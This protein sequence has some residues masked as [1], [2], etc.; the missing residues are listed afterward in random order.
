[1]VAGNWKMNTT[2]S[3]GVELAR[4]VVER[5][6]ARAGV[7][8]AVLPS[9]V[10]LWPV[11][12]VLAASSVLLGAQDLFWED[13]G[14]FTGEV[15]PLML[16]GWCD[17][18]LVGH[19][20]RR[21]LLGE[22]DADTARKVAAA[23][24]HGLG[25]ILAVGET[26]AERDAGQTFAVIDRQLDA[27]LAGAGEPPRPTEW[28]VAYEPVWAIGTGRTATPEQADEVCTH[29]HELLTARTGGSPRVLYGG[30]VSPAN[31][32]DLFGRPG[33][34]GGLI[35]GASLDPGAFAAIVAAAAG[36]G[37]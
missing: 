13:A 25:V 16:A 7:E 4:A 3:A 32:A 18:V 24:R 10:H 37:G 28:V 21:H 2:V 35:G 15:S 11:R 6:G 26:D 23:R 8:V 19:S 9:F 20:E 17:L 33:I 1:M 30:S 14:A 36:S 29:I 34:D 22:T 27:V 31:A 12:D 5:C